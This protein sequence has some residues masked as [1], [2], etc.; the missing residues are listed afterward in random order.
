[1]DRLTRSCSKGRYFA[2]VK[3]FHSLDPSDRRDPEICYVTGFALMRLHKP[4]SARGLLLRALD[5]GFEGYRGWESTGDLLSR[6]SQ[7][8]KFQPPLLGEF[9]GGPNTKVQVYA[10]ETDWIR[11]VMKSMPAFMTRAK[12][13]FGAEYPA[14]RFYFFQSRDTFETF[15]EA[16]FGRRTREW[17]HDGTGNFNVVVYCEIDRFGKASRPAGAEP[18]IADVMHEYGH[19]LCA[20]RFGDGYLKA[21]PNWLNEGFADAI[22]YPFY[23]DR[24]PRSKADLAEFSAKSPAPSY[25]QMCKELYKDPDVG[26]RLA[27]LMVDALLEQ[28]PDRIRRILDDARTTGSFEGALK[29]V[30]GFDG[31][32]WYRHVAG[33][34]W[35]MKNR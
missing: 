25:R 6:I 3:Y 30:T 22:A 7:M 1:M 15:Y 34:F 18:T 27:R 29:R 24:I 5:F 20:M 10:R 4:D 26:Y 35:P 12:E 14:T 32:Y 13:L 23:K 28:K 31:R 9:P 17:W 33:Q 16:M 11:P 21:V 8:E 2:T 19:S